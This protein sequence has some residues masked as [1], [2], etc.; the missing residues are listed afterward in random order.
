M[1]RIRRISSDRSAAKKTV[2]AALMLSATIMPPP[3][4]RA[5][6]ANLVLRQAIL[7][8]EHDRAHTDADLELLLEASNHRDPEIQRL[9][10]RALGR[11]ERPEI[12]ERIRPLLRAAAPAVRRD[13]AT[14]YGQALATDPSHAPAACAVMRTQLAG[15]PEDE[16]RASLCEVLG[17]LPYPTAADV[18]SAEIALVAATRSGHAS[19]ASPVA[20]LGAAR[21]L[22]ALIRL[23]LKISIPAQATL[24]RLR[25][26]SIS[27]KDARV[28]RLTL[29]ALVASG[30]LDAAFLAGAIKDPDSQVRRHAVRGSALLPSGNAGADAILARALEDSAAMVRFEALA[31]CSR[32]QRSGS[33]TEILA[34]AQDRTPSVALQAID[35]LG[36]GCVPDRAVTGALSRI[37]DSLPPAAAER[38]WHGPAHA[39][40]ALAKIAPERARPLLEKFASHAQWQV[41]SYAAR[42]ARSVGDFGWLEKLARDSNDNVRTAAIGGLIT[43]RRHEAD[44]LYLEALAARDYQLIITAARGLAGTP[45]KSSAVA[46]LLASLAR[47]TAEHSD[48]SRDPRAAILQRLRELG[49]AENAPALQPYLSDFD[50]RMALLA[51]ESL[52]TW[53]G[54]RHKPMNAVQDPGPAPLLAEVAGLASATAIVTMRT[55]GSFELRLL[56]GEAPGTVLRFVRLA[57]SGYYNGLTFHRVEPNFVIQGGSPGANEYMGDSHYMRDE[58]GRLMHE[59]GT[60]GISTRGRDTGDAQIF[61]NLVDNPRLDPDYTVFARVVRGLERIDGILEGDTIERIEI[62]GARSGS[63][64]PLP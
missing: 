13:A 5:E 1:R 54:T 9:A 22:E 21:G 7:T 10:V 50:P 62:R 4:H 38:G 17:R 6:E 47:L 57:S 59:R 43:G 32:R 41:R 52:T 30:K 44:A 31:A 29:A 64:P 36:G 42:A 45:D 39:L 35:L 37:A 40:A 26:L 51:A 53:T 25:Q 49:S 20:M 16:V 19:D 55:G 27:A 15:E 11:L 24:E 34:A 33:C 12:A 61:L 3:I 14:A 28:R 63:R 58:V 18:E 60:A 8:A 48:T 56:A 23:R 2:L 46:A